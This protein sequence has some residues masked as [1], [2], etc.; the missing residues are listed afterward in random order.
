[1]TIEA[2]QLITND[3]DVKMLIVQ[4]GKQTHLIPPV[5]YEGAYRL[6]TVWADEEN[7]YAVRFH[8]G[9]ESPGD[10]GYVA[11]I[12][13]LSCG[14]KR[15]IAAFIADFTESGTTETIFSGIVDDKVQVN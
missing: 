15:E 3:S 1:M 9:Y 13:P 12:I 10:N 8:Y 6:Q 2:I 14:T 5:G 7:V 11:I 4:H